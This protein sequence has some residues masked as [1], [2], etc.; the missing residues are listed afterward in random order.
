VTFGTFN[1][2]GFQLLLQLVFQQNNSQQQQQQ[3]QQDEVYAGAH[4]Q[5]A[6]LEL[7][8]YHLPRGKESPD[9]TPR[10]V[11]VGEQS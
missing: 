4:I 1:H 11:G 5:G 10:F 8:R 9:E 3:Q 6:C 7:F 2:F